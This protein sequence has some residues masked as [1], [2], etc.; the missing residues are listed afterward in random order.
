MQE[1]RNTTFADTVAKP[2]AE[3]T[4]RL[5][6]GTLLPQGVDDLLV[7][8]RCI[9]AEEEAMGQLRLIP[10]CS[11]TGEAAG[12]AAA[13]ALRTGVTPAKLDITQLQEHLAK[14]GVDLGL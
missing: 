7:A 6:Y 8:G 1:V 12:M 13:L 9:S 2:Y 14:Q 4:I 5:P 11:A 10:V 3:D